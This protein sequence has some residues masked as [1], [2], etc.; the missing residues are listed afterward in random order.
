MILKSNN[1]DFFVL[2]SGRLLQVLVVLLTLR[3]STTVLPKSEL[4]TIYYLITLH[5]FYS[6][7]FINPVGQYFNRNTI[8]WYNKGDIIFCFKRQ[9]F[10]ITSIAITAIITLNLI[11]YFGVINLSGKTLLVIG[12]LIVSQSTNQTI[13]PLINMIGKREAFVSL[14]LLTAILSLFLSFCMIYYFEEKAEYWLSGMIISNILVSLFAFKY[15]SMISKRTMP[16]SDAR[17]NLIHELSLLFK[18][19]K[20]SV[21]IGIATLFMWYLNS[22]YRIQVENHYG[23]VYLA[24]IGVGL[25]ISNQV[26]NIV[27]SVLTQYMIPGLYK[28]IEGANK[29]EVRII[30]S[31]YLNSII[32]IYLA[33]AIFLSFSIKNLLPFL[34]NESFSTGYA[35]IIFGAWIEFTRVVTNALALASQIERK[36]GSF[37][38]AYLLGATSLIASFK[39]FPNDASLICVKLLIANIVV[40]IFMAIM[41]KK[42]INFHFYFSRLL[43][44]TIYI[45]PSVV[46]FYYVNS[47]SG[48]DFN[49]FIFSS[50]G[51]FLFLLFLYY[52]WISI[53]KK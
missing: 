32:P 31:N 52:Y 25:S 50:I 37:I 9:F 49:N 44:V 17:K 22:G 46:F 47:M 4:G 45:S 34:V 27:E 7:F 51:C 41:M 6:L 28:S 23:L 53:L 35:I 29:D 38:P 30:Y 3:V 19:I 11:K 33:V 10:Y 21:P 8:Y 42:I 40:V 20:F 2:L 26:F 18:V 39:F 16:I 12:M 43:K 48:L 15:L 36:T 24:L 5:T 1:R 14:N 13:I